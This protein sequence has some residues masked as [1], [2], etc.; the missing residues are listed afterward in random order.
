MAIVLPV[1]LLAYGGAN[2]T[3]DIVVS[4][5]LTNYADIAASKVRFIGASVYQTTQAVAGLP[6]FVRVLNALQPGVPHDFLGDTDMVLSFYE[7]VFHQPLVNGV[8]FG[9]LD[10]GDLLLVSPGDSG[11]Y[12]YNH[13]DPA[14][15]FCDAL[16]VTAVDAA[17]LS[18]QTQRT[19][20][21]VPWEVHNETLHQSGLDFMPPF[22]IWTPSLWYPIS[23]PDGTI[24]VKGVSSLI[25]GIS[26]G[27]SLGANTIVPPTGYM[28]TTL[29]LASL[30]TTLQEISLTPNAIIAIWD[31]AGII[32]V[33]RPNQ[34]LNVTGSG[35][36]AVYVAHHPET[37]PLELIS[38]PTAGF[39]KKYG[40]YSQYPMYM[41]G[42]FDTSIGNVWVQARRV[43]DYGMDWFILVSV[44]ATDIIAPIVASRKKVIVTSVAVAV[45]M[46]FFAA[47]SSFV[48]TMP[49][50]KLSNV[51]KQ[52]TKMDF[53]AL[54]DGYLDRKSVVS[55][56]AQMQEVFAIMMEKFANA[57]QSNKNLATRQTG[58]ASQSQSHAAGSR[59]TTKL[60]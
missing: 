22:A 50:R 52:A 3:V 40:T 16:L 41:E 4:S 34:V 2:Q 54:R 51:M 28:D 30:S 55:E 12:C 11:V 25:W 58:S 37:H 29:F 36:T 1:A 53:S 38:V 45:G 20:K 60:H 39:K 19:P 8:G 13:T 59:P 14:I 32:A 7:S 9:R 15:P 48:V 31:S 10:A 46:L 44:P 18:V 42:S 57:I 17:T 6:A 23:A 43:T 26:K 33:S 49:L 5:L 35:S 56:L 24:T 47:A 27:V 21:V